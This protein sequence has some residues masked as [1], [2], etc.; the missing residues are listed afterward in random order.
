MK[1][2]FPLERKK[3]NL[4]SLC[5][6]LIYFLKTVYQEGHA[7]STLEA[8]QAQL[9]TKVSTAATPSSPCTW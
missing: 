2:F 4:S 1:Y 9:A 3:K 6:L 5:P 7:H 8:Q